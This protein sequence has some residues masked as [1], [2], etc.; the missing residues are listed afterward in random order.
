[1]DFEKIGLR[2]PKILLPKNGIDMTKWAVIACDQYTS[3]KEYWDEVN[4]LVNDEPSTLHLIFPEV[5]LE[6]EKKNEIVCNI[7]KNMD[8]YI[9][10]GTLI[11]QKE[12][13]IIVDRKTPSCESRKGMIVALDLEKYDYREN[14]QTLIRPTEGTIVERL[15]P[16]IKIR[17]NATMELPHIIVL[18]DDPEKTVIEP[19]FEKNL[20]KI[21]DFELMMDGGHIKG[22]KVD[23]KDT[24]N[25]IANNLEKLANPEA[26][27]KKYG[28]S[29]K[30]ILL[31]AMGDGNHSFATAKSIWEK[32]KEEKGG[33]EAV[34]NH[35][36]RY[37]LVEIINIHDDGV[38][39]EPI[40]RVL[41]NINPNN[42]L[43]AM[44]DF[45]EKQG[46][47]VTY[48]KVGTF[49]EMKKATK[50]LKNQNTQVISFVAGNEYGVISVNNSQY[51]LEAETIE[52]F[53]NS[54]VKENKKAK[55]DYIHGDGVVTDLGSKPNN[56]GFYLPDWS[57]SEIFKTVIFYGV[58]PRKTFSIGHAG[59][60]K[61]YVECRKIV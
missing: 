60:K 3:Q 21:Y 6:S 54:Y 51:N 26:F 50:Q 55:I 5:Y 36:A 40:H 18:I 37:A 34:K 25:Q 2:V 31:Y 52:V 61:Y 1:M 33:F 29:D 7:N 56:I 27:N 11:E 16:R 22:Y 20:E 17:E 43:E 13:F 32:L 59:D 49:D 39:I 58:Y 28:V 47:E 4:K 46:S 41:F 57:K 14:S 42:V 45:Y 12:G 35:P 8:E 24:I 44:K 38:E 19:L 53:L 23:D 30:P 10:N 48:K 9:E 15:K